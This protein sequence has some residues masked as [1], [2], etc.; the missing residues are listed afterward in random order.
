MKPFLLLG[1]LFSTAAQAAAPALPSYID[2]IDA[3]A[4][5]LYAP[6]VA[7]LKA[8]LKIERKMESE[9]IVAGAARDQ[10]EEFRVI[11][12]G[13]FLH[14]PRLTPDAY[15]FALCHELG[16]LFGGHPRRPIPEEWP[17]PTHD[18]GLSLLSGEGQ[19]D[20]YTTR[21]CFRRLVAGEDHVA[22]LKGKVIPEPVKKDCEGAWGQ[23]SVDASI[24]AR[25]AIGGFEM[26]RLVKEFPISFDTRDDEVVEKTLNI[27]P[28]R[29]CRLDTALAG[30]LCKDD[31]PLELDA[32][33]P[34]KH[35]CKQGVGARPAC[36]FRR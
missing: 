25:A 32:K 17:G 27:Y 28:S 10:M 7:S 6:L 3:K 24:C 4:L 1:L 23:G 33:D 21:V 8:S 34:L 31:A 16:H 20:Y 2:A 22:A 15:R 19:A 29:Q 26:L 14:A 13:G 36:W 11:F 30:A 35:G 9:L 18:D 5:E 12:D